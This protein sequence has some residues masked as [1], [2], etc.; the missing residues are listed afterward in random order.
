MGFE[1]IHGRNSGGELAELHENSGV[2]FLAEHSLFGERASEEQGLTAFAR[3]GLAND[4]INQFGS[5]FAIGGVYAGLIPSRDG[6]RLGFALTY[7][8]NGRHY[9]DG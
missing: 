1:E 5:N 7:A 9:K 2:Y 3:I 6:D 4:R 8:S